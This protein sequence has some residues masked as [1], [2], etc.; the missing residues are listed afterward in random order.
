MG[1]FSTW[2][3]KTEIIENIQKSILISNLRKSWLFLKNTKGG[4]LRV[5]KRN[6]LF[7]MPKQESLKRIEKCPKTSRTAPKKNPK[8]T[9]PIF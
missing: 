8:R 9:N 2:K 4:P 7:A 3:Q 5:E 1:L 6:L